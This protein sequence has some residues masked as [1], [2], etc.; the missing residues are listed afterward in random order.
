MRIL[1]FIIAFFIVS[2]T[3]RQNKQT[4]EPFVVR[5]ILTD[6]VLLKSEKIKFRYEIENCSSTSKIIYPGYIRIK[7]SVYGRV[8][9]N[10]CLVT[11]TGENIFF[12]IRN[13]KDKN[14]LTKGAKFISHE[15]II[16]QTEICW[17]GVLDNS[18]SVFKIEVNYYDVNTSHITYSMPVTITLIEK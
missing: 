18:N 8:S 6:T 4:D 1:V 3:K 16:D 9:V 11:D 10:D 5:I 14:R 2:F 13:D 7:Y 17:D 12:H 15:I